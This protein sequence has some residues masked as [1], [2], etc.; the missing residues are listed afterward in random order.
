[1]HLAIA[2]VVLIASWRLADWKNWKKYQSTMYYMVIGSLLYEFL[3]EDHDAW[4]FNSD[5]LFKGKY[6]VMLYALFI[7]PLSILIFLSKYPQK[8]MKQILYLL[9]WVII[10][11]SLEWI[12]RRFGKISYYYGWNIWWSVAFDCMMFPV[13][14]LHYI[15]PIWAYAVSAVVVFFLMWWFRVPLG[16]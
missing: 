6:I 12:L 7:T 3:T 1:M 8:R 5:F 9:L 16:S 4:I 11:I 2:V 10:Y 14:I 13:L 15:K